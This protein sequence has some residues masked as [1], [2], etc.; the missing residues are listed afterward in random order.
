VIRRSRNG[1][2]EGQFENNKQTGFGRFIFVDGTFYI[3]DFKENR[4]TG[5]GTF[6]DANGKFCSYKLPK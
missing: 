2:Y 4:I 3:G 1:L 6:Y 5:F